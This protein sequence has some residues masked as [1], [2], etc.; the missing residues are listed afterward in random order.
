M[1]VY[2]YHLPIY[3]NTSFMYVIYFCYISAKYYYMYDDNLTSCFATQLIA[4]AMLPSELWSSIAERG[5]LNM[6]TDT[7]ATLT[8]K[9]F[10]INFSQA[11]GLTKTRRSQKHM[12]PCS[13][14]RWR[15]LYVQD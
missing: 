8:F 15:H 3:Y 1:V 14:N 11:A 13:N 7:R 9:A 5:T 2:L 6:L 12:I 10:G 4:H